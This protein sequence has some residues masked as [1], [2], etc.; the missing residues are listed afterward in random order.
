MPNA[1][2]ELLRTVWSSS[3]VP[4]TKSCSRRSV[5]GVTADLTPRMHSPKHPI[6]IDRSAGVL[7]FFYYNQDNEYLNVAVF[8]SALT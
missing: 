5:C 3:L 2:A 8:R 1:Y 6:A 7:V 4:L